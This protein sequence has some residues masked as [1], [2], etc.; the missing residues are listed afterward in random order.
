[1]ARTEPDQLDALTELLSRIG[2]ADGG[3]IYINELELSQWP[4]DAVVAMK[5]ARLLTE[6]H[7][8]SSVV[9][10]GCERE[11]VMPVHVLAPPTGGTARAFIVCDKRADINRVSI[12]NVRLIQWR[13]SG[14][15]VAQLLTT[16]LE[17][18]AGAAGDSGVRWESGILK[19]N[20]NS[21]SHVVMRAGGKLSLSVAGHSIPVADVLELKDGRFKVNRSA[22]VRLV[23]QPASG[24]GDIESAAQRGKRLMQRVKEEKSKGTRGFLMKIAMEEDISVSRLKQIL[25]DATA[26]GKRGTVST[27]KKTKR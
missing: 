7:A 18:R 12:P 24:G 27:P 4:S 22:L 9:C 1:M 3:P 6:T 10:P 26:D 25:Q 21:A 20:N 2:A 23:N 14:H 17:A 5:T 16:L 13:T 8:A 15:E 11:C 19:G